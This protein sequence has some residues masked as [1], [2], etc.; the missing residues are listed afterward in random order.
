MMSTKELMA[1]I[2][3]VIDDKLGPEPTPGVVGGGTTADQIHQI[4]D[5]FE[6]EWA[7]SFVKSTS[8]PSDA[9]WPNLLRAASFVLLD[10]R[11]WGDGGDELKRR[12]IDDIVRFLKCA[13]ESLVP[14]FIFTNEIADDVV[15]ELPPDVYEEAGSSR[16]FVF[17]GRKAELWSGESVE[18]K[19]LDG[20]VHGNAS[21]YVLRTWEQ[22][23][24]AAKSGALSQDAGQKCRLAACVLEVV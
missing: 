20:W 2:A 17:V 13:K 10:W 15:S 14:V 11:L 16:N 24:A 12:T 7:L 18:V 22:V 23:L 5:W 3:V 9:H 4:V 8:L 1:G 19:T 6:R 21:V